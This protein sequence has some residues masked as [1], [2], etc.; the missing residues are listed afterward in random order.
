MTKGLFFKAIAKF[1]IGF[2]IVA[3][4]LFLSAGTLRWPNAWLFLGLLFIPMFIA[5]IV[6]MLLDPSLLEKRLNAKETEGE[7]RTVIALSAL[8][9][10]AAFVLAGLNFRFKWIEVPNWIVFLAAAVFLLAYLMY[11]E[12]LRENTYLARTVGVS[13]G[14]K[15]ISTGLYGVVRHPM[16]LATLFLF[17]AMGLVL[18]SPISFLILLLY[19][20]L[21]VKRIKNEEKVLEAE[22]EGYREYE[23]RIKYRLIPFIW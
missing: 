18:G 16:Y 17:P 2:V 6:M 10:L 14:Q 1:L 19:I 11:A 12:V 20:P 5:G 13:E 15:V 23:T 7:Q 3:A 9:F 4:I 8:M 22:L 21:I